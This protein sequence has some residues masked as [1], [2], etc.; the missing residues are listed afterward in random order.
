MEK[1][2]GRC[3]MQEGC[4]FN[5]KTGQFLIFTK[6]IFALWS[7]AVPVKAPQT[8]SLS[9]RHGNFVCS[10]KE[11]QT[12]KQKKPQGAATLRNDASIIFQLVNFCFS[13]SEIHTL[14][15]YIK[16]PLRQKAHVLGC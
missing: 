4:N 10:N 2:T 7:C 5:I 9:L 1:T 6:L 13:K 12:I 3:N 11:T 15:Q 16:K 8:E 14:V